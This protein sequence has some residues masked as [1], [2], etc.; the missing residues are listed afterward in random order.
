[1]SITNTSNFEYTDCAIMFPTILSITNIEFNISFSTIFFTHLII[2]FYRD[3]WAPIFLAEKG[4]RNNCIDAINFF[5]MFL[6]DHILNIS[7]FPQMR[8]IDSTENLL[9]EH[10]NGIKEGQQ[11]IA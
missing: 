11:I 3:G 5:C 6:N 4:Q 9:F 7:A 2:S 1:M 10:D 8:V